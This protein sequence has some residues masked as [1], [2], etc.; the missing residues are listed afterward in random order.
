M[1]SRLAVVM[2]RIG[3][4]T[5][6]VIAAVSPIRAAETVTY[7][8]TSPQGSV[9]ATT[10]GAG[11]V[12][13]TADYRPYGAQVLGASAEG[14]GYTGQVNDAESWLVYMQARYF[15][16]NL[17][18]FLSIDPIS[19][20]GSRYAYAE[21]NPNSYIDSSGLQSQQTEQ[22][23]P[24]LPCG[25]IE[26]RRS[27]QEQRHQ[28]NNEPFTGGNVAA[29]GNQSPWPAA[30]AGVTI[31]LADD[32]T[33]V[34]VADDVVVPLI[35]VGAI[36]QDANTRT[37]VTY[38]LTDGVR[39]Y[40]GRTSG[41]G[42]PEQL[43]MGRFAGHHMRSLGYG[44]PQVDRWAYGKGAYDA[45]R[46]REQQLIDSFGGIGS[47]T[48]GNAIRGVSKWNPAGRPYWN[49]SNEMFGPLAPYTGSW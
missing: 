5:L 12:L 37:Y 25:N 4:V 15:D 41:F 35:L 9:L 21:N 13:S 18:R 45:I 48:S 6:G 40:A 47:P 11:N 24:Q 7:Y 44:N 29:S 30:L 42:P 14:P 28:R 3:F 22:A 34:G 16:P 27:Q 31:A 26:C 43:V 33:G 19:G 10:D 38:T 46:G 8:Y 23:T 39:T 2:T 36:L 20:M 1:L 32:A 49:A 17:G